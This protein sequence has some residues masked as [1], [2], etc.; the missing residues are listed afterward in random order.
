MAGK[1]ALFGGQDTIKQ[2][3][4]DLFTW[5]IITKEDEDAVLG[6]LRTGDMSGTELTKEFEKEFAIWQKRK[7]ALGFSTGTGSLQA[8][9]FACG[10]GVGDEIIAPSLTYWAT[11]LP[12]FSLG[13]TVVFADI[14]EESLNIDPDE[15]ERKISPHT[16]AIVVVHYVGYPA[17]MDRIMEISKS[18]GIP[19]IEDVSHA[20][21]GRY[22]GRQTGTFGDIAAM[23]LMSGKS[24]PVGEAGMLVT[25]SID[26]YERAVAF[27]H[28]GRFG[29]TIQNESIK[30]YAGLPMG[31][32][33]YRMHQM[34]SAVGR[35]QLA[36]YDERMGEID[37]AMDYFCDCLDGIPGV[38]SHRVPKDSGSTMAGWYAARARYIPEELEGLSVSRFCEAVQAEGCSIV[39]GANKPLHLH[40]LFTEADI[41]GHG[42]PTRLANAKRD[43]LAAEG[44]LPI[45]EAA[46]ARLFSIPW[47]KQYRPDEIRQYADAIEKVSRNYKELLEGDTG[48]PPG[49]GG[50]HFF[51][52][53][54]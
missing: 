14:E 49:V 19:V 27:G 3:T 28:Y 13:A 22:K 51:Q 47:F 33:K 43:V 40:P 36:N 50:W 21:G 8:A 5:P 35:V 54:K 30:K 7:L 41:Y 18:R 52:H 37:R 38:R 17:D 39:P 46:G 6:V 4:E 1:L 42:K 34:S 31:G 48:N 9:M 11:A 23:S 2:F 24:L 16:K 26:L 32:Y 25:D 29:G 45:T 15:I 53:G 10:V 44:K 20:H 12:A